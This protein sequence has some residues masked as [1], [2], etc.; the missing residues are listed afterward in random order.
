MNQSLAK[1]LRIRHDRI[2]NYILKI[3][4][5]IRGIEGFDA[6]NLQIDKIQLDFLIY[7]RYAK[8]NLSMPARS[9]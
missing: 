5:K 4:L 3:I 9:R 6:L 7:F 8:A 1:H 2:E